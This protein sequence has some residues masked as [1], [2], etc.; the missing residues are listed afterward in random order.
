MLRT[1]FLSTLVLG[2]VLA[3][4]NLA[5]ETTQPAAPAYRVIVSPQLGVTT[6]SKRDL[7]KIFLKKSTTWSGG[8]KAIPVDQAVSAA[9]RDPFSRAVHGRTAKAV[10]QWWNQ[11]IY[12][13]AGVPPPELASDAKV[14][15]YVLAN[16]GA[17]GYV[18]PSAA[19][20]EARVLAVT[21]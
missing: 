11:Q 6:I 2:V 12:S 15:A 10:K 3:V 18:G 17:T 20:G 13:G 4:S 1:T 19:I 8:Q 7:S 9:S 16:P 5:A 21:E 14:V